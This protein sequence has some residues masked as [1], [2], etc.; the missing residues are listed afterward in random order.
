[1]L[2][3]RLFETARS[4][5]LVV[6]YEVAPYSAT[7]FQS[8]IFLHDLDSAHTMPRKVVIQDMGDHRRNGVAANHRLRARC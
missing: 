7:N 5:A 2:R 6:E 8:E 3:R 1:M 4:A